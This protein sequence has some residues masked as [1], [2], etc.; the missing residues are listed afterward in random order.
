MERTIH[1]KLDDFMNDENVR[2]KQTQPDQVNCC[3]EGE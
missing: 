2:L 3:E 1:D